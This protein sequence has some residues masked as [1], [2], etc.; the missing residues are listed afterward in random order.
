MKA[1]HEQCAKALCDD[2][3]KRVHQGVDKPL[4]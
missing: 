3:K 4:I 1:D 2:L